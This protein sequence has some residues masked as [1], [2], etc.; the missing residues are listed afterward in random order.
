[1][2][3]VLKVQCCTLFLLYICVYAIFWVKIYVLRLTGVGRTFLKT[4]QHNAVLDLLEMIV[5]G[6]MI[7]FLFD[8]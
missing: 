7:M 3:A 4:H 2:S 6:L 1:M 5:S 8:V